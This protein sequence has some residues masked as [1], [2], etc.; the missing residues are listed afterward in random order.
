MVK[1][2]MSPMDAIKSATGNAAELLGMSGQIGTI[3]PGAF[4]D[5]VAVSG[6]PLANVDV[7]KNVQ[8][9]MKDGKVYKQ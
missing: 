6:D 2:G 8:F 7:L 9:V 3:A 1:D 4:A 5:I